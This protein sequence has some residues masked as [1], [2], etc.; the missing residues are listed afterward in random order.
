MDMASFENDHNNLLHNCK[1]LEDTGV[2]RI[3]YAVCEGAYEG[4]ILKKMFFTMAEAFE[5]ACVCASRFSDSDDPSD[6]ILIEE[7]VGFWNSGLGRKEL[8]YTGFGIHQ[9]IDGSDTVYAPQSLFN[10]SVVK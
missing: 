8:Y 10:K 2:C 5:Y 4:P 7:T 9:Y 6:Y 1:V 3:A